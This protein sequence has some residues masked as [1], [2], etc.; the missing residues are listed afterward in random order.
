MPAKKKA[1]TVATI[2]TGIPVGTVVNTT[3]VETVKPV[4]KRKK[5]ESSAADGTK[6]TTTKRK[7]VDEVATTTTS[8]SFLTLNNITSWD[9]PLETL[10]EQ[11]QP[12][13]HTSTTQT[14]ATQ[15]TNMIHYRDNFDS[16]TTIGPLCSQNELDM[17]NEVNLNMALSRGEMFIPEGVIAKQSKQQANDCEFYLYYDLEKQAAK[18]TSRLDNKEQDVLLSNLKSLDNEGCKIAFT[19]IRMF[20]LKN[21]PDT[22]MFQMPFGCKVVK[23]YGPQ[24]DLEFDLKDLPIKLQRILLLFT[25]RHMESIQEVSVRANF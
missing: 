25:K 18:K 24:S 7:K 12:I 3:T 8:L 15:S 2:A 9:T 23:E 1:V 4:T 10:V 19:L 20:A 6:K 14:S 21:Q 22:Q 17:I 5:A 13:F 11:K 16:S